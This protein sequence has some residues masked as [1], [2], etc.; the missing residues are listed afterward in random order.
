MSSEMARKT[1]SN[2][3]CQA[4]NT[5]AIRQY[6]QLQDRDGG[7]IGKSPEAV[8]DH[9]QIAFPEWS[10]CG[11]ICSF[12]F[13]FRRIFMEYK[14]KFPYLGVPWHTHTFSYIMKKFLCINKHFL[15][16]VISENILILF[17]FVIAFR[18]PPRG[19]I[20]TARQWPATEQPVFDYPGPLASEWFIHDP[21][22]GLTLFRTTQRISKAFACFTLSAP[23]LQRDLTAR[24]PSGT[25]LVKINSS[26]LV[27]GS[28]SILR[29]VVI[30]AKVMAVNFTVRKR[31]GIDGEPS[32]SWK[33]NVTHN[34]K[35]DN[36]PLYGLVAV[37]LWQVRRNLNQNFSNN[38]Y[39]GSTTNNGQRVGMKSL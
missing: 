29:F 36:T 26:S 30:P 13:W 37:D 5:G 11:W 25:T 19:E 33:S 32:D 27:S 38:I 35:D 7:V 16:I 14:M 15:I 31:T 23:R 17:F 34:A 3:A 18:G 8:G 12:A 6:L 24:K 28:N 1:R 20:I 9:Q 39:T 22:W 21:N 2:D 4:N 10:F